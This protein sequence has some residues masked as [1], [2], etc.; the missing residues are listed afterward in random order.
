MQCGQHR[1]S[2]G[3]PVEPGDLGNLGCGQGDGFRAVSEL[4]AGGE[5]RKHV[6]KRCLLTRFAL[7][8]RRC[9]VSFSLGLACCLGLLSSSLGGI[10][11]CLLCR[12]F[13]L[14]LSLPLSLRRCHR[15]DLV[16]LQ[17]LR[18]VTRRFLQRRQ[19]GSGDLLMLGVLSSVPQ[20]R[21]VAKGAT[22]QRLD[23][24]P[25]VLDLVAQRSGKVLVLL[26]TAHHHV[27]LLGNLITRLLGVDGAVSVLVDD[28]L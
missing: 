20:Q 14:D 17:R 28:R 4:R 11:L 27:E 22:V 25:D 15:S 12:P 9:P 21:L 18:V 26:S 24:R 1:R 2:L 7:C 13:S 8:L 3:H 23:L 5:R 16:L 10:T 6:I 19:V